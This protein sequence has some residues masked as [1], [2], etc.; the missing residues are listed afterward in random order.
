MINVP[1]HSFLGKNCRNSISLKPK[2]STISIHCDTLLVFVLIPIS[3]PTGVW[4]SWFTLISNKTFPSPI[5]AGVTSNLSAASLNSVVPLYTNGEVYD[6][7]INNCVEYNVDNLAH[8][9]WRLIDDI[10]TPVAILELVRV[11]SPFEN[12]WFA[13]QYQEKILSDFYSDVGMDLRQRTGR[14][15]FVNEMAYR[16][17]VSAYIVL[18]QKDLSNFWTYDLSEEVGRLDTPSSTYEWNHYNESEYK[19]WVKSL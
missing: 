10:P 7:N 17:K 3:S 14:S 6:D 8:I 2:F 11:N 12:E 9:E 5:M 4:V 15:D 16:L 19:S 1:A 13:S 18:F